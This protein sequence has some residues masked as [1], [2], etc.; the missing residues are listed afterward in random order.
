MLGRKHRFPLRI[1]LCFALWNCQCA[2]PSRIDLLAREILKNTPEYIHYDKGARFRWVV[3]GTTHD[4]G[5]E[6][7]GEVIKQ[8]R[9]KYTVYLSN[10]EVPERLKRRSRDGRLVGYKEGLR[11]S[12]RT[13]F[14]EPRIVTIHYSDWEGSLAASWHWKRYEW[15]GTSWRVVEKSPITVS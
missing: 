15:T 7:H 1:L 3:I 2:P 14:R 4:T 8:L 12:F 9:Q 11:F 10:D 13:E 6:L 5:S